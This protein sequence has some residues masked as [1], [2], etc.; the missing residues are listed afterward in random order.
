MPEACH[1]SLLTV[2]RSNPALTG[3]ATIVEAIARAAVDADGQLRAEAAVAAGILLGR[4]ELH[5]RRVSFGI[6]AQGAQRSAPPLAPPQ[7]PLL[8]SHR[9][10]AAC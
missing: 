1:A 7:L 3:L 6:P 4:H 10:F 9:C 5:A 2:A 8:Y